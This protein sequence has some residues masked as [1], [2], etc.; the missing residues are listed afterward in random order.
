MIKR[1]FQKYLKSLAKLNNNFI[2]IVSRF[3]T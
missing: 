3:I 1:T 2:T